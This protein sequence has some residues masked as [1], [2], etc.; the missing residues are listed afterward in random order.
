LDRTHERLAVQGEWKIVWRTPTADNGTRLAVQGLA[1]DRE[2]DA[3]TEHFGERDG[4]AG[5]R[6]TN[7]QN[8]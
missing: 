8:Q 4:S 3:G 7:R 2:F 6:G 1:L 5:L